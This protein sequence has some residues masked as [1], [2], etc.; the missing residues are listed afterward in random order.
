ML[1]P[2]CDQS[3]SAAIFHPGQAPQAAQPAWPDL[4]EQLDAKRDLVTGDEP[5]VLRGRVT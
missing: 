2:V 1:V 5:R 4:A 3:M